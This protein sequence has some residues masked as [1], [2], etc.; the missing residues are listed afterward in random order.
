MQE[1]S[2]Y[3]LHSLFI[4]ILL[5]FQDESILVTNVLDF[6]PSC[7][8]KF[9]SISSKSQP[10]TFISIVGDKIYLNVFKAKASYHQLSF[11]T[12]FCDL[13]SQTRHPWE[14]GYGSRN[15]NGKSSDINLLKYIF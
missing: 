4:E 1:N 5:F 13:E 8:L 2:L 10:K 15:K 14:R 9:L 11:K 12:C 6:F 7:R 3:V